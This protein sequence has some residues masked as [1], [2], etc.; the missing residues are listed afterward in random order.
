MIVMVMMA[1][2]FVWIFVVVV[3][4][5]DE[6]ARLRYGEEDGDTGRCE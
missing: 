2:V 5:G 1:L 4:L 6:A 3:T